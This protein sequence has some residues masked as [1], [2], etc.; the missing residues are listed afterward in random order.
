MTGKKYEE[1]YGVGPLTFNYNKEDKSLFRRI[2]N[3]EWSSRPSIITPEM[4]ETGRQLALNEMTRV[5][6]RV[7]TRTDEI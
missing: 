5:T 3:G 7:T 4:T 1:F 2:T 6:T